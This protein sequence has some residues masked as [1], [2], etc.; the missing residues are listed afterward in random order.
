MENR[1]SSD[2]ILTIPLT[3]GCYLFKDADD[4]VLYVG[5]SKCLRKRVASYFYNKQKDDKFAQMM[6]FAASV[7]YQCTDTDIEAILMEHKLIKTYRPIYNVRMRKD[8]QCWYIA[9][10]VDKPYPGICVLSQT[11]CQNEAQLYAGPFYRQENGLLAL[12]AIGEYWNIP[13]CGFNGG[14]N[15]PATPCLRFHLKQCMGPCTSSANIKK[16]QSTIKKITSF[17]N[18]SFEPVLQDIIRLIQDASQTMAYEKAA[19]LRDQY[20]QLYALAQQLANMPPKLN[21]RNFCVLVKSRHEESFLWLYI[22]DYNTKAWMRF[23]GMD[24]WEAKSKA[25]I[26]YVEKGIKPKQFPPGEFFTFGENE[27]LDLTNALLEVDALHYF[28]DAT[29][30]PVNV[31]EIQRGLLYVHPS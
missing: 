3:P 15:T 22:Q 13:T 26:K 6:L 30:L 24:E 19:R 25:M 23:T 8:R 31:E 11:M 28:V 18:G 21:G 17:L 9:I 29:H 4:Q 2:I 12:E 1:L 5:K 14:K 10:D 27:G 20:E 7:S 16:Y